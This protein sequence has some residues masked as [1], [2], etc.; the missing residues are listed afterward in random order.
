[1][2]ILN[3]L[4]HTPI[5]VYMVFCYLIFI[6][7]KSLKERRTE[8]YRVFIIPAIFL[9]LFLKRLL[10]VLNTDLISISLVALFIGSFIGY[11]LVK[12]TNIKVDGNIITIPGSWQTIILI[13]LTFAVKYVFGYMN[14][15]Y[16]VLA[17][18]HIKLEIFLSGLFSGLFLGRGGFYCY[19]VLIQK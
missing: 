15:V 14:A 3:I 7:I 16:P 9:F 13:I 10:N 6:G 18:E 19:K 11:I 8:L 4:T 1:M 2:T 17:M 5:W 12:K